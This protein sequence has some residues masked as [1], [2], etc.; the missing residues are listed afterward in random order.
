LA[1]VVIL[2][3][4]DDFAS[5]RGKLAQSGEERI[6]MVV[7]PDCRGMYRSISFKLLRR[8]A[9]DANCQLLIVSRD[10]PLKRLAADFG[11]ATTSSIRKT[12]GHW[13]H[14]DAIASASPGQAW[15]LRH[16]GKI[17]SRLA[18]IAFTVAVLVGTAYFVLPVATVRLAPATYPVSQQV[19][20]TADPA[21]PTVD[22]T[23]RRIPARVLSA[24]VDASDR[25]P[26]TGKKETKAR[27]FVT[28][29]NMTD[30]EVKLPVGTVVTTGDGRRFATTAVVTVP[31]PKY[32]SIRAEV[33]AVAEGKN[34]EADRLAI[35]KVDGPQAQNV[36]VLNEQ[37]IV[38]DKS[39]SESIVQAQDRDKLRASLYDRLNKQAVAS[40]NGQVKQ[41]ETL[42]LQ[43]IRVEVTQED[44]DHSVGDEATTVSLRL[45]L[46]ATATIIDQ[47]HAAEV[48]RKAQEASL[49]AGRQLAPDSLRLSPLEVTG[50]AGNAVRFV[51]RVEGVTTQPYDEG[52]IRGIVSGVPAAQAAALLQQRL[53]LDRLPEVTIEPGWASRA[54]RVNLVLDGTKR[55]P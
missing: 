1:A 4:D 53:Q 37:P 13:R 51:A 11:F 54:Y 9:E 6:A 2:D 23:G 17:F 28:F 5:A 15:L 7:P 3:K 55:A 44:F 40:L 26:T 25:L 49:P 29:G 32:S 30:A 38:V 36:A 48:A 12:E 35:N 18:A 14:L 33:T 42:V 21:V 39:R 31:A 27:G 34:G 19:E 47:R 20:V 45:G 52:Q 10:P 16:Q 8:W 41:Y 43:T 50:T 24:V 46:R 22:A